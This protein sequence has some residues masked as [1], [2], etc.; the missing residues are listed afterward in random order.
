MSY[1]QYTV[2]SFKGKQQT[3]SIQ[4]KVLLRIYGSTEH[5]IFRR[6][7]EVKLDDPYDL[8]W[9]LLVNTFQN[10]FHFAAAENPGGAD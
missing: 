2:V 8:I 3:S 4:E 6:E 7:D 5:G 9:F 1:G 10:F